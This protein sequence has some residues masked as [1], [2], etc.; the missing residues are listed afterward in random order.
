MPKKTYYA[1]AIKSTSKVKGAVFKGFMTLAESRMYLFDYGIIHPQLYEIESPADPEQK[2]DEVDTPIMIPMASLNLDQVT[3]TESG[4]LSILI[5]PPTPK[6]VVQT[7]T[8][9]MIHQLPCLLK[10]ISRM[11]KSHIYVKQRQTST[12]DYVNNN[13]SPCNNHDNVE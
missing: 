11:M 7:Y 2:T 10:H 12:T 5:F 9:T 3:H 8:Q 1:V 13:Q 6:C 4:D